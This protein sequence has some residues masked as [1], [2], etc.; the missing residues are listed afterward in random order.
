M[1]KGYE[2]RYL[3]SRGS[4]G[5]PVVHVEI[6]DQDGKVM[7]RYRL[8]A[9]IGAGGVGFGWGYNG[10]APFQLARS[11]LVDLF[12][13][14]LLD[15]WDGHSSLAAK[16]AWIIVGE[17]LDQLPA[18]EWTRTAEVF[19]S[20]V[21][22]SYQRQIRRHAMWARLKAAIPFN[23]TVMTVDDNGKEGNAL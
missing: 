2:K 14:S 9:L 1:K 18:G 10:Q 7:N 19:M 12:G 20:Q 3:G 22:K 6:Y 17:V 13:R 11:I 23:W 8:D 15:I 5:Q 21:T 16:L 4:Y